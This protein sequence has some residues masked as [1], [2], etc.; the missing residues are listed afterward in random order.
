MWESLLCLV[1][2]PR[3]H[4][5]NTDVVFLFSFLAHL[6]GFPFKYPMLS[7]WDSLRWVPLNKEFHTLTHPKH[8]SSSCLGSSS[9]LYTGTIF[10]FL[11][12]SNSYSSAKL[13]SDAAI[14]VEV[15]DYRPPPAPHPRYQ[16]A[17]VS[18]S[19]DAL[20]PFLLKLQWAADITTLIIPWWSSLDCVSCKLCINSLVRF[21]IVL[22]S[23]WCM[24]SS[25]LG[26]NN[27]ANEDLASNYYVLSCAPNACSLLP[28][29]I[30]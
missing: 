22:N 18:L 12:V 27:K 7:E 28:Y 9:F 25:F 19:S 24:F 29:L 5:F 2:W 17:K 4:F 13:S 11:V 10:S 3:P 15:S 8:P 1:F 21:S 30:I 23:Y 20:E 16:P 6:Q 14:S 26:Y